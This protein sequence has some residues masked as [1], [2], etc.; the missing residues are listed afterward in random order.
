MDPSVD[1][2][3]DFYRYTC[4]GWQKNN[5]IPPDQAS[6]DVYG[7]LQ[8]DNLRLLW[9]L[10]QGAADAQATR[11]PAQ[12]RIGD[13]FAACMDQHA[14]DAA[15]VSPLRPALARIA[16]LGSVRRV[17][18]LLAAMHMHGSADALFSFSAEQDFADASRM[19][20]N[21]DA[22]GLAL[23]DRDNYLS[24][25]AHTRALRKAYR[26]HVVHMFELLGDTRRA[27]EQGMHAVLAIET[28]LA[29]ASLAGDER[30]DPHRIYHR[31]SPAQL[32]RLVPAFDWPAY[33]AAMGV[34]QGT[35]VNVGEPAFFRRL[36]TLLK[37]RPLADWKA[38]LRWQLVNA[39]ADT[40]SSPLAQAHFD[41]FSAR[42]R[43][44]QAAPARW[45]QC[46]RW[47]DRDLGDALGQVFVKRS[48]TP[49][50]KA[51][52]AQM[53]KAIEAAMDER[54][55]HLAWMSEPTRRAALAKLHAVVNKIGYPDRWRDDSG[56]S[57]RRD[58]FFGNVER[59][60]AFET[61]RS[62]AKIGHPVDRG[63][64][65]MTPPTVNAYY[66]WQLNAMNFPAG[67]LQPPLFDPAMDAATNYGNTGSTIGHELTHGFDDAGRQFDA[68]GNLADWW[69]RKDAAEFNRRA[70]CLVKQYDGYTAVDGIKLD[71]RLTLGEN[72]ADL[73]G[74]VLAYVAWHSVTAGQPGAPRDGFTPEQRFFIGMGQWA[75]SNDRLEA[76]RL[77]ALTDSHAPNRYRVNGVVA[78]MPEFA[79]AFSCRPGQPMVRAKPCR[80]W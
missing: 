52:A 38:Y 63:E 70:G 7:K 45:K 53:T 11:T 30:V 48:F 71:G 35:P 9:G 1:A 40:L 4:G 69:S 73:G 68:Q 33:F 43:G 74:A 44:V 36:G 65:S 64:W 39:H 60:Q 61:R 58:D 56:L 18:P 75:C 72:V 47:V 24:D 14:I 54:I 8:E 42:L 13:Y 19:I 26:A 12:Q 34:P 57:I 3:V 22:G 77:W 2:C 32:Q 50:T 21:V 25:D 10:L 66:D 41:F 20:A 79:R 17:A 67:V 76:Q 37:V 6:W 16:A 27:A 46:V 28:E 55:R 62:V 49:A 5:P 51:R 80:V 15:G 29:R 78:N 23:P 59:A 31:R